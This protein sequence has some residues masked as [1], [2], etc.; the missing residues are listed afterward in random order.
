MAVLDVLLL[1]LLAAVWGASYLFMR[2]AGP[3]LG[4]IALMAIRVLIAAALLVGVARAI[5][6]LPRFRDRWRSFLFIGAV[7]N[8]IPFVLIAN[9]VIHLNASIAAVLNATV[10]LFTT[11]VTTVWTREPLGLRTAGGAGLGI[12]GVAILVGWSPLPLTLQTLFT[13]AQALLASLS[14]GVTAVYARRNFG[15]LTPLQASVGQLCGSTVLLVPLIVVAPPHRVLAWP[16][17]TSLLALAI[18]CTVIAYLIYFR[19]IARAGP[20][21]TS[22][23]AFL[24]P[25]FSI[26]WGALFLGEPISVG[27]F[28]GLGVILA[29]LWLV[30]G[31]RR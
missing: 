18:P 31:A 6:Q 21:R 28:A 17:V 1:I 3:P 25:V 10:P 20:N 7:G 11:L 4:P 9:A 26:L 22:T 24:I 14:Y 27:L 8:A 12:L 19:L 29:S 5:H 23:V 15:D 16:I 30:L 2:V 13:T